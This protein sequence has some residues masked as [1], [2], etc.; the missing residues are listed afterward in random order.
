MSGELLRRGTDEYRTEITA[1]F[2]DVSEF[3][4]DGIV[5]VM[6]LRR[7]QAQS[8]GQKQSHQGRRSKP[9]VSGFSEIGSSGAAVT[10]L[11]VV[12]ASP[13][14]RPARSRVERGYGKA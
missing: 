6:I 14:V 3:G 5:I 2:L 11:A 4:E 1:S 9:R 12:T 10:R 7:W 8:G 13:R